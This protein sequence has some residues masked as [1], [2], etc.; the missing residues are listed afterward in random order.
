MCSTGFNNYSVLF[1]PKMRGF[2]VTS[3][4]CMSRQKI[5]IDISLLICSIVTLSI[6]DDSHSPRQTVTLIAENKV[7]YIPGYLA[8]TWLLAEVKTQIGGVK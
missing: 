5:R 1:N 4:Y 6:M 7:A 8:S 3:A 2:T